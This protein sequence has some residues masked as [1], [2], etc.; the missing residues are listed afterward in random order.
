MHIKETNIEYRL[1]SVSQYLASSVSLEE[2][3]TYREAKDMELQSYKDLREKLIDFAKENHVLYVYFI[4]PQGDDLRFIIDND[5]VDSMRVD[6]STPLLTHKS[7]WLKEAAKGKAVYSG[8][9]NYEIGWENIISGYAP[10]LGKDGKLEA[11]AG[12][13]INDKDIVFANRMV[14]FLTIVRIIAVVLVFVSGLLSLLSFSRENKAKSKFLATMSHEIRTPMNAIIGISE[15]ELRKEDSSPSTKE[16]ITKI[17]NSGYM[18]LSIINDILDLSKIETGKL[19]IVS[20]KYNVSSLINDTTQIN[21]MRI[22]TKPIEFVLKVSPTIPAELF[23]DEL[24]IKQVLNNLLSNAFKYTKKGK[25]ELEIYTEIPHGSKFGKDAIYLIAKVSDTGLGMTKHQLTRLFDEYSRF[26][27]KINRTVEGTGLGMSIAKNIANMLHGR[28]DVESEPNKGSIFTVRFLQKDV[29]ASAIGKELAESLQTFKLSKEQHTKH[30]RMMYEH[31]PYGSV[32]VVDDVETNLF[33]ARGLL[34]PYGLKIE[35]ASSGFEALEKINNGNVY[36]IVF[37]DHMMPEMDGIETI[38]KIREAGYNNPV[39]ALT[40]NAVS[41]VSDLFLENGFDEFLS[42]P[43]DIRRL[44]I[45]LKKFIRNK[46]PPKVIEAALEQSSDEETA[47]L[48]SS[49]PA[50][51]EI[52]VRDAKKSL[53]IIES[54]EDMRLFTI[55]AHSLKSSLATIGEHETSLQAAMLE[56]AGREEDMDLIKEETPKFIEALKAVIEKTEKKI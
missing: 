4:R 35:V 10:M 12:V 17:Y 42:K 1:L 41:G 7:S 40:A 11:I 18:L 52:F 36:D 44:N 49:N 48:L 8:L 33:V 21:L 51:L 31:M 28:I 19:E 30:A 2:L 46:Q 34:A 25:V 39:I 29:G 54:M 37:L 3:N 26:N 15:I 55:N 9:G 13:D 20:V 14:V 50:L 27:M 56:K 38:K 47:E 53:Q 22:G 24:R 45:M 16:A 32:L 43:V 23:G 6:L 5:T